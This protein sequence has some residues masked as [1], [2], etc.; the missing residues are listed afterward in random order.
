MVFPVSL[1][2]W[3]STNYAAANERTRIRVEREYEQMVL[4]TIVPSMLNARETAIQSYITPSPIPTRTAIPSATIQASFTPIV[5]LTFKLSFY[6]PAIG[7]IFPEIAL[8]NC[9]VWDAYL[10]DCT[11]KV[12][13]G[14]DHYS[15]WY[16]RGVACPAP[17][18]IGQRFRVISPPELVA[19]SSEWQCIDRGG[20]IVD[21]YLDFMLRYPDD[22]WSGVNLNAFPWNYPVVVEVLP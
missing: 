13:H 14:Q 19:V 9:A 21:G 17:F 15:L 1:F 12:N 6:D 10:N 4:S 7:R 2:S 16:R 22:I 5:Q 20:A 18:I 3:F 8:V 11:S